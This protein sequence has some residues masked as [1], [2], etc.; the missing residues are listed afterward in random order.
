MKT[1]VAL[2]ILALSLP[3]QAATYTRVATGANSLRDVYSASQTLTQAAPTAAT[4]GIQV[5][6]N[7]VGCFVAGQAQAAATL[8][9]LVLTSYV[10]DAGVALWGKGNLI[11]SMP[12]AGGTAAAVGQINITTISDRTFVAVLNS[13]FI[14]SIPRGGR[15]DFVSTAS[16]VSAGTNITVFL[17]CW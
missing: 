11:P 8:V 4:E 7:V 6:P 10:Y 17:S 16:T 5:P 1:F 14:K 9:N 3:A 2:L 15:I 13:E 12:V